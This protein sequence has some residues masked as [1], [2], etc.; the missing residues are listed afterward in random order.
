[1]SCTR[2]TTLPFLLLEL[3]PIVCLTVIIHWFRVHSVSQRHFWIFL[4]YLIENVEQDQTMYRVQE[5]QL[6]LSYFWQ[7]LAL[8]YLTVFI[9]WF[10]VRCVSQTLWKIFMILGR[11]VEQDQRTCRIQE[12]QLC[13]S[14]IWC[15]LPLLYLTVISHW[16]CVSSVS[17][18]TFGIFLWYMYLVEM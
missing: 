13:L 16:F 10:L 6:C 1:M 8:L 9:H 18:R 12:W 11:N 17:Q 14:Y 3:F 15:N 2:M 7:Y 4:W 5:R